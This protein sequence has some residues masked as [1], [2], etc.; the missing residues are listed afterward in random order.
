VIEYY[1]RQ[2]KPLT[3]DEWVN[4]SERRSPDYKRVAQT[5]VGQLWVSTVWLGLD[6][7]WSPPGKTHVPLI[8]ETM[9]FGP[10]SWT[11]LWMDR[12]PTELAALAGHDQAVAW[13]RDKNHGWTKHTRDRIR[14]DMK[15]FIRLLEK[16]DRDESEE[17]MLNLWK[18]K[19]VRSR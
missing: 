2:G 8:F 18:R 1:D 17:M 16:S 3:T 13:A 19:G 9:V 6:H 11:D 10:G 5:Q 15:K 12:Y 14:R 7:N 4:M